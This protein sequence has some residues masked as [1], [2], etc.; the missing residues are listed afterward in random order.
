ML[1]S[2]DFSLII[3]MPPASVV[4]PERWD[5]TL[6]LFSSQSVYL[7]SYYVVYNSASAQICIHHPETAPSAYKTRVSLTNMKWKTGKSIVNTEILFGF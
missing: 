1:E 2:A 5:Q 3:G 7:K 4:D 6:R